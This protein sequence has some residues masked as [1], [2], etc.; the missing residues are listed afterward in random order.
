MKANL[1]LHSRFSDGR[2]FPREI[3]QSAALLGIEAA[4]LTD[5]DT[6]GGSEAFVE[7]CGRLGLVGVTGCEMDVVEPSIDYKSELLGYFPGRAA[8]DCWS[9]NV[10]LSQ[11]QRE[12]KK[13]IEYYLYWAQ[14]IFKRPDLTY[15]DLLRARIVRGYG[16]YESGG[17]L[18]GDAKACVDDN[19]DDPPQ[20]P[21]KDPKSYDG[22]SWS[23]VDLFLY[24]RSKGLVPQSETY[25][26]FKKEWF[27]PGRFPKYR[28]AKPRVEDVV[29]AVHKDDG[30]VV[31]PHFG[32]LWNDEIEGMQRDSAHFDALLSYF[33][34]SGVDGIELYW[35]ASS[36]KTETINDF[37]LARAAPLGFFFTYGS[38]CHGPGT[39]KCTIDKFSG[40]FNGF[41]IRS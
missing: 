14:V 3:A 11:A 33:R 27:V 6:M 8:R 5:H 19:A 39:D 21:Q 29:R 34:R 40:N 23:K 28:L 31:V 30:F 37:V 35:Y 41:G 18:T 15:E 12:R 2:L 13:R 22:L 26:K 38:D 16:V 24:L 1:H 32:H 4:A 36:K 20:D 9:T 25:R 10:L 17:V 7:E